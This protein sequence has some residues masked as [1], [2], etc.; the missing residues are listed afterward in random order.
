[1][2]LKY[3]MQEWL[4][5][6]LD[7]ALGSQVRIVS[8]VKEENPTGFLSQVY[9]AS[10]LTE[11]VLEATFKRTESITLLVF[12]SGD[13]LELFIKSTTDDGETN[14]FVTGSGLDTLEMEFYKNIL[15]TLVQFEKKLVGYSELEKTFPKFYGGECS[16]GDFYLIL[17]N[18]C[19]RNFKLNDCDAG[20]D[21]RRLESLVQKEM[22]LLN[23]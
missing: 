21:R 6:T 19:Q 16:D 8:L 11:E 10:V 12:Q 1:M 23:N 15:P 22:I 9:Y 5:L 14:E 13:I 2:F 18:L 4:K 17:E 20:L 3:K 7:Q